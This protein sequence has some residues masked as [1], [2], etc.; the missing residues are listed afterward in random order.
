MPGNDLITVTIYTLF[1]LD[2]FR[3]VRDGL[4]DDG[5]VTIRLIIAK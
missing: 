4:S 2:S 3:A 5:R 1:L